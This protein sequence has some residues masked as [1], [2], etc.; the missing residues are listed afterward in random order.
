MTTKK[1]LYVDMDGVVADFDARIY[2][3]C[4]H[5]D[6][7]PNWDERSKE[8]DR[9]CEE[10]YEIFHKLAPIKDAIESIEKLK[11]HYEIYFLSTP[12]WNVPHSFIGK[13]LWIRDH[14][15]EWANKRLILSHRKD[16]NIG[17]YLID[18]RLKNGAGEFKGVHIHFGT[19]KFPDWNSVLKLL[20][21]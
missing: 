3:L 17:A 2:E 8:V 20:L 12:M 4:P 14:F 18:D 21:P 16:L 6:S 11:P 9:I 5:I 10:N 19:P 13:R 1:I 7:Y 15:G